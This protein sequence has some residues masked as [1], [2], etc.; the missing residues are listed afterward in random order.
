MNIKYAKCVWFVLSYIFCIRFWQSHVQV[1]MC[2]YN[3]PP[4]SHKKL[5]VR[6]DNHS[7]VSLSSDTPVV[8]DVTHN[9][10]ERKNKPWWLC[11]KRNSLSLS[12]W[13]ALSRSFR[14]SLSQRYKIFFSWTAS[15]LWFQNWGGG[16][17]SVRSPWWLI[18]HC[19]WYRKVLLKRAQD[20][21]S[22][23]WSE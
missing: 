6:L 13:D 15:T 22:R 19:E 12:F 18:W 11:L 5:I 1:F 14:I 10:V 4:A 23:L 21:S 2:Q 16:C 9:D 3:W 20:L 7:G 8:S 17:Q